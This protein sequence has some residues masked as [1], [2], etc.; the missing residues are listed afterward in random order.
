MKTINFTGDD[1]E[2]EAMEK[3]RKRGELNPQMLFKQRSYP[4]FIP[5]VHRRLE[6]LRKHLILPFLL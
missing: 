3:G 2:I 6:T 1:D 5:I 4:C